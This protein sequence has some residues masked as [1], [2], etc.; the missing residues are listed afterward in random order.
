[1]DEVNIYKI[2]DYRILV[3][4]SSTMVEKIENHADNMMLEEPDNLDYWIDWEME[5]KKWQ[6]TLKVTEFNKKMVVGA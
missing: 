6:L 4:L 5:T 2:D 3:I 1:M